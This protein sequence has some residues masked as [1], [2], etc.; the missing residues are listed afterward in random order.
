VTGRQD[1]ADALS[2]VVGVVGSAF[3][4]RVLAPGLAFPQLVN[5]E[6]E[7]GFFAATW[8]AYVVLPADEKAAAE[9]YDANV[10]AVRDALQ[11]VM[12][13]DRDE[14]VIIPVTAEAG[15]G[16]IFA[17]TVTGRSE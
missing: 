5:H 2:Q 15:A 12:Y 4:P 13:V 8:T 11:Q 14:P 10:A 6:R 3:R 1:I 9:W 17:M 7:Q 16:S